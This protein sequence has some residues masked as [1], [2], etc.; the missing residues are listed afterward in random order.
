M[1]DQRFVSKDRCFRRGGSLPL[2]KRRVSLGA[3]YEFSL[4]NAN[5]NS[6]RQEQAAADYGCCYDDPKF[7]Y[8]SEL[9]PTCITVKDLSKMNALSLIA[10]A[11][12]SET[13]VYPSATRTSSGYHYHHLQE[14][15]YEHKLT[16][17]KNADESSSDDDD[18]SDEPCLQGGC[19]GRTSRNNSYCRRQPCYNGSNFC[20]LHYQ[21]KVLVVGA[22]T[23]PPPT[24]TPT[25]ASSPSS[26]SSSSISHASK[27]S[28][29]APT[30]V[31]SAGQDKRYTGSSPHE[32]RCLATT[33][34]GRAC[35][36]TAVTRY[37]YLHADYDTNPPPR[38]KTKK[39]QQQQQQS[40]VSAEPL[41]LTAAAEEES[42]KVESLPTPPPVTAPPAA[43]AVPDN[44]TTATASNSKKR[45]RRNSAKFAEYHADTPF[46]LLS[47]IST[48]QWFGKS[49]RVATGPLEG[50]V[51]VVEKWGNGWVSVNVAGLGLHNRRS[52]ELYLDDDEEKV[53]IEDCKLLAQENDEQDH[54]QIFRCVSRDVVSPSPSNENCVKAPVGRAATPKT[55]SSGSPPP[56]GTLVSP[57]NDFQSGTHNGRLPR[58]ASFLR[59][60]PIS[61]GAETP[62]PMQAIVESSSG[63]NLLSPPPPQVTPFAQK[64]MA[65]H[66]TASFDLSMPDGAGSSSN[67][68]NVVFLPSICERT[69]GRTG[70]TPKDSD[71]G[72]TA[73]AAA[74]LPKKQS[75][76]YSFEEEN[77]NPYNRST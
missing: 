69:R 19:H 31:H 35:A 25:A 13:S 8:L 4:L 14:E 76:L 56:M 3:D 48:D 23:E 53:E 11:A 34:R 50:R 2:K 57:Q 18:E 72:S 58:P 65:R 44:P 62:V 55:S 64:P 60:G 73:A 37:C 27:S 70:N 29:A 59:R 42:Y 15:Q 61:D 63:L 6:D 66:H 30:T 75:P 10:A 47:M 39:E 36:Y 51:G 54:K 40:Q 77:Y 45:F 41:L 26:S 17:H 38:R 22:A 16:E 74:V 33:T 32:V 46:P 20:K 43:A 12:A 49:V 24:P 21:P 68:K 28:T 5:H 52:F 71:D 7:A 67:T 9:P 1:V